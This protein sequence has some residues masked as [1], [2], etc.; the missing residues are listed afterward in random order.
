MSSSARH[1]RRRIGRPA[2]QPGVVDCHQ[3][4]PTEPEER[5]LVAI[6]ADE[7]IDIRRPHPAATAQRVLG[8]EG[9]VDDGEERHGDAGPGSGR[10]L[11]SPRSRPQLG[12]GTG[13]EARGCTRHAQRRRQTV[14]GAFGLCD[15]V[16]MRAAALHDGT[17]EEAGR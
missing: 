3:F 4:G 6:R 9:A 11:L 1:V 5:Q 17:P 8:Q 7:Q 2:N 13:P 15:R 12:E 16:H 10:P 14:T